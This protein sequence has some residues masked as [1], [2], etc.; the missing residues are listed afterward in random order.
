MLLVKLQQVKNGKGE[1]SEKNEKEWIR[2]EM[3]VI[4]L[5]IKE[6]EEKLQ[7]NE[8]IQA[9]KRRIRALDKEE[10]HQIEKRKFSMG[11]LVVEVICYLEKCE[12]LQKECMITKNVCVNKD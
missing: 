9:M 4:S 7:R 11:V 8:E 5:L 10:R 12:S 2:E 1:T 3:K 6:H